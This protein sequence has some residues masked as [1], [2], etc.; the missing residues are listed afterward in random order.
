MIKKSKIICL[1]LFLGFSRKSKDNL[2]SKS[3]CQYSLIINFQNYL[4]LYKSYCILS[5]NNIITFCCNLY[6]AVSLLIMY[7]LKYILFLIFIF[8][9]YFIGNNCKFFNT[10]YFLLKFNFKM[11]IKISIWILSFFLIS[12]YSRI[13]TIK[14]P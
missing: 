2:D 7:H 9:F 4:N 14:C 5:I 8:L 12:V 11:R 3:P 1:S 6:I 10:Q 13:S